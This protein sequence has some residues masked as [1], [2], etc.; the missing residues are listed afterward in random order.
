MHLLASF[1]FNRVTI[2]LQP[3]VVQRQ[4]IILFLQV[5][6]LLVQLLCFMLLLLVGHQPIMTKDRVEPKKT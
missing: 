6:N 3:L 4:P 5:E 2:R 1:I